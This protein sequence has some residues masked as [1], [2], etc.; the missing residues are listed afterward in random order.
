MNNPFPRLLQPCD[1]ILFKMEVK[2]LF[3]HPRGIHLIGLGLGGVFL[4]AWVYP[5]ASPFLPVALTVFT[6][7]EPQFNN[8]LFRSPR[9]FE[10]LSV[11]PLSWKRVVLVKNVAAIVLAIVCLVIASMFL[12]YFSPAVPTGRDF[13]YAILYVATVIFPLLHLGNVN[14]ARHPRRECGLRTADLFEALWQLVLLGLVSIPF[15]IFAELLELP[16]LCLLYSAAAAAFWYRDSIRR[17]AML[18]EREQTA[19]CSR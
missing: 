10:S 13:F 7:L 3:L 14:S 8:I 11:F 16:L 19:L 1:W 2:G 9:E 12:L 18:I 5:V 4:S 17:T 6:G 15:F